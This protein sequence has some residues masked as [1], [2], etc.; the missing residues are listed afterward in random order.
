MRLKINL[1]LHPPAPI[2]EVDSLPIKP[3]SSRR[4]CRNQFLCLADRGGGGG[5][6]VPPAGQELHG[7]G[8]G[9]Q[10]ALDKQGH[11]GVEAG[12]TP[13]AVEQAGELH[14]YLLLWGPGG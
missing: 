5:E 8:R 4:C 14:L 3:L 9:G 1:L 13:G 7:G 11:G 10:A 6:A 12:A 2:G